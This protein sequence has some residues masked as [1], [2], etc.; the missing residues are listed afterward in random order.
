MRPCPPRHYALDRHFRNEALIPFCQ[1]VTEHIFSLCYSFL[2]HPS[3]DLEEFATLYFHN[4]QGLTTLVITAYDRVEDVDGILSCLEKKSALFRYRGE[5][6]L[7][8][9]MDGM[10]DAEV[11]EMKKRENEARGTGL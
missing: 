6:G 3:L 8:D 7:A 9:E 10:Y 2:A 5:D 1:A 4:L 11:A